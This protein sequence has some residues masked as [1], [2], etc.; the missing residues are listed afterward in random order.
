M[1]AGHLVPTHLAGCF[2]VLL[3]VAVALVGLLLAIAPPGSWL[4]IGLDATHLSV[5]RMLVPRRWQLAELVGC[6]SGEQ[7]ETAHFRDSCVLIGHELSGWL[8]LTTRLRMLSAPGPSSPP[9]PYQGPDVAPCPL[10]PD[11]RVAGPVLSAFWAV[12]LGAIATGLLGWE[13]FR[14]PRGVLAVGLAWLCYAVCLTV[15]AA[16]TRRT[17]LAVMAGE[18]VWTDW[19]HRATHVPWQEVLA[20]GRQGECRATVMCLHGDLCLDCS[21]PSARAMLAAVE[22]HLQQPVAL[23]AL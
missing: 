21:Q 9:L 14:E 20:V 11:W 22:N 6:T 5:R 15:L 19:R 3:P 2:V 7:S 16:L 1:E 4:C 12:T 13:R 8:G 17:T 23:S 18:L 10:R